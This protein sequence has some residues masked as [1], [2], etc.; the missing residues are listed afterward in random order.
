MR[1]LKMDESKWPDFNVFDGNNDL[2][3]EGYKYIFYEAWERF[4]Q[5]ENT[6]HLAM[7]F[8]QASLA[9]LGVDDWESK[10]V[11]STLLAFKL[12]SLDIHI[13]K[14]RMMVDLLNQSWGQISACL[15][16]D[17]RH[18]EASILSEFQWNVNLPTTNDFVEFYMRHGFVFSD[19]KWTQFSTSRSKEK[20]SV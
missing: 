17:Q 3:L 5:W 6:M 12:T 9:V 1:M 14:H 8:Y 20:E 15:L 13:P 16:D 19:D 10:L 18:V 4:W 2:L 7:Y 11:S